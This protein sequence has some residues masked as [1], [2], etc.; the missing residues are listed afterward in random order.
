M[1]RLVGYFTMHNDHS[2]VNVL[3][4]HKVDFSCYALY[5]NKEILIGSCDTAGRVA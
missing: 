3:G 5:C 2:Q 4:I 1:S